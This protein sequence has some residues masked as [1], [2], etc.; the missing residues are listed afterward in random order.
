MMTSAKKPNT[1]SPELGFGTR[2][3]EFRARLINRDGTFN[4]QRT[5]T[6]R[7]TAVSIYHAL[8][9]MKWWKF[10]LII[11]EDSPLFGMEEKDFEKQQVE[12]LISITGFDDT[13]SQT[14]HSRLSYTWD[15][16]KYGFRFIS[17]FGTDDKGVTTQNMKMLS[18]VE[19]AP[20]PEWAQ[21]FSL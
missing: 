11:E 17:I 3:G 15:E 21:E 1:K 13:F 10:N 18:D 8:I 2:T 6:S 9:R 4:I 5:E 19:K 12:F 14:V 20:L 16:L 7:W